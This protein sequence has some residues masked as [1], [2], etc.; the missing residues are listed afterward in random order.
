MFRRQILLDSLKVFDL[1]LVV[2]SFASAMLVVSSGLEIGSFERLFTMRIRLQNVAIFLGFIVAWRITFSLF[3]L[4]RSHRLS[5]IY[6]EALDITKATFAGTAILLVGAYLFN[7]RLVTTGFIVFFWGV[8]TTSTIISRLLL[9]TILR[10][11]RI[12][13]RNLR[14]VIIV[15]ANSRALGYAKILQSRPD[16]GYT[17]KGFVD[18][19]DRSEEAE[20]AGYALLAN[21]EGFPD[22]LRHSVVDEVVIALPMKSLYQ[23]AARIAALC[24]EQGVTT[25]FLT[26]LFNTKIG[27][28]RAE[29]IGDQA[30]TTITTGGME[31]LARAIK[32]LLDVL[33]ACV[34]LILLSP[35]F[36]MVTVLIKATSS[37][38]VFFIQRRVGVNKR[39]FKLYKFRTMVVDA[40]KQI[41]ELE[42]L[43]EVKGP[44]FK[45]KHDPRINPIGRFLRKMS[46]DELPQL[47]NVLKGDMSLVGPRPLPIRDYNGFDEDW[48]RRRFSVRPGITCLW[49]INGRSNVSFDHWMALDMEYID[50]WS[51]WLDFKILIQT[52]PAV[53]KG[54]GAA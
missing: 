30:V 36:L 48:H 14:N 54:S 3:Q 10:Q 46:I 7:I 44:A 25:R 17:V 43:N 35:F 29:H 41:S 15:G 5:S 38:P 49:Q 8:A 4:Y 31:G 26:D 39:L 24:E 21:L 40:E 9:R 19:E 37:G 53:L 34:A 28:A 32:R 22:F 50:R 47:L 45:I 51:L 18:N 20:K 27:K 1:A 42:H 6:Q 11:L 52:I 12:H 2:A 16:L 13:G 33:V 23:Q